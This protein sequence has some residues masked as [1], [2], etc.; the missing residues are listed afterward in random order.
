MTTL[1]M[2]WSVYL[3]NECPCPQILYRPGRA[4]PNKVDG[5]IRLVKHL[6]LVSP[7]KKTK[8]SNIDQEQFRIFIDG[9][10]KHDVVMV[11]WTLFMLNLN[12]R[13]LFN[14]HIYKGIHFDPVDISEIGIHVYWKKG[15]SVSWTYW[16]FELTWRCCMMYT[17]M[18]PIVSVITL[19]GAPNGLS[20]TEIPR[21]LNLSLSHT[22]YTLHVFY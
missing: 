5:S 22:E 10:L 20:T 11:I 6:H 19:N 13:R 12:P 2:Y 17:W 4:Y 15:R 9:W 16:S 8:N 14:E 18:S 21:Q 7:Y 3:Q 1:W